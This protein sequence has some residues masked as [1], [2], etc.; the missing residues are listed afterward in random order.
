[1]SHVFKIVGLV[2]AFAAAFQFL[3]SQ[4]AAQG[5]QR[6][7]RAQLTPK[8]YTTIAAEIGARVRRIHFAEGQSFRAGQA[9]VS[10]DCSLQQAQAQ[11][12]QAELAAAEKTATANQRLKELNSIG[13]LEL[14]QS[15]ANL[16]KAKAEVAL[17]G[18][19]LKR[20]SIT[21]PYSGRVAEQKVR[22]Q[23]FAQPG[24]ALL[25][26]IDDSAFELEFL[27]PSRTIAWL[28][29][30][31]RFTV[32]MDETG[33]SYPAVVVRLGARIDPVS[34][35]VKVRGQITGK[36]PELLAGMS[37]VVSLTQQ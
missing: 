32:R 12:S 11:K 24:Q 1:M 30:G 27:A 25:D 19:F 34:Q 15:Q 35:S 37:G 2:G 29:P 20:C 8:R 17:A 5:A 21:A 22:E 3:P 31:S 28:R 9:L 4:A 23:Q 18:A 7:I 16:Q 13:S 33:R 10:L 36:Y 6:Q 26:I 14:E